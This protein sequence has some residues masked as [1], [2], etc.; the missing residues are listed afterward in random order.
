MATQR[1][2][3]IDPRHLRIDDLILILL[4]S[5]LAL[6]PRTWEL[7]AHGMQNDEQ[8]WISRSVILIQ[9]VFNQQTPSDLVVPRLYWE[10]AHVNTFRDGS[11]LLPYQWPFNI[12][13]PTYHPGVPISL[14]IGLGYLFL[15]ED[16]SSWSLNLDSVLAVSR[17]PEV[18]I[19]TLWAGLIYIGV[20]RLF[21]DRRA[22]LL[23]ALLV[24]VDP[25]A[26]GFSRLARLDMAAAV[27]MT[28][29]LLS[30]LIAY[31]SRLLRYAVLGGI[32]AGLALAT[33][34]YFAFAI[35]VLLLIKLIYGPQ[36]RMRRWWFTRYDWAFILAWGLVFLLF[37]PNLWPNPVSGFLQWVDIVLNSPHAVGKSESLAQRLYFWWAAPQRLLPHLLI[38]AIFGLLVGLARPTWR[39]A[40]WIMLAW[41]LVIVVLFTVPPAN[42]YFR[43]YLL[44]MPPI[45][46]LAGLCASALLGALGRPGTAWGRTLTAILSAAFILGGLSA[47]AAW[48]PYPQM[49]LW[50]W[51]SDPQ[52]WESPDIVAEGE[53]LREVV[54][55]IRRENPDPAILAWTGE[56]NI[57]FFHAPIFAEPIYED[58]FNKLRGFDWLV[59]LPKSALVVRADNPLSE[60]VRSTEPTFIYRLN[61]VEL[62]R[63]Y[64]LADF[65]PRS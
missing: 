36:G 56:N 34:P 19:G 54:A 64:R 15:A 9:Q 6:V 41:W 29:A 33:S 3:L 2:T 59:V 60:W 23:A 35:P 62:V 50:P 12:I 22:A 16:T 4:L 46:M 28:G 39:R 57:E 42:K 27:F 24:A 49:H 14:A 32:F 21:V 58:E 5:L 31:Q 18:V 26:I 40:T 11:A 61:Q 43:N 13:M 20:V 63:A 25:V 37:Y 45:F 17:Y 51:I 55:L 48:W 44:A 47:T 52:T 8:L 30:F 38:L 1:V 53:G 7:D 10:Q 65:F